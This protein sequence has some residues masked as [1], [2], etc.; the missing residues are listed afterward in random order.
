MELIYRRTEGLNVREGYLRRFDADFEITTDADNPTNDFEITMEL[1]K[2]TDDLLYIENE[3]STIVYVDGTEWGGII[4]GSE[5]D[6]ANNTVT[7]SGWTWRGLLQLYIIE[8][9]SGQDYRMVSANTNLKTALNALPMHPMIALQ[10]TS[11]TSGTS[12]FQYN[13]YITVHEGATSLLTHAN[14]SY[15]MKF[16]FDEDT[17]KAKLTIGTTTDRTNLIEISQDYDD[18]VRL[19]ISRDG[20]TPKHLI[21]LGQGE[22]KDRQVIHLY[23]DNDWN[24]SQTAISGAYPVDTYDYSGS[25]ALLTDGTKHYKELIENHTSVE[26]AVDGIDLNLG[27]IIAAREILTG[28]YATAEITKII[29]KCTDNGTYKIESFD[30]STKLKTHSKKEV[31]K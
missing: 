2:S 28:E 21:C 10:N 8:P 30:Y 25:D 24:V 22:L 11:Y 26:V 23:A 13:R 18:K 5:I 15:R 17:L 27:D 19:S 20:N 9:P 14:A 31:V 1:P 6:V 16:A 4:S 29:W 3:V 12:Q 7:Y